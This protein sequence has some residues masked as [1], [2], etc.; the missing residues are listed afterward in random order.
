MQYTI[1]AIVREG[2]DGTLPTEIRKIIW[3]KA[4]AFERE[5][6]SWW[7]LGNFT[8]NPIDNKAT[9]FVVT[10]QNASVKTIYPIVALGLNH[11]GTVLYPLEHRVWA[12][13]DNNKWQ[14]VEVD[15]CTVREQQGFICESNTIKAQDICLDTEHNV[16][17]FEIH[18]KEIPGTVLI[19]WERMCVHKNS[20]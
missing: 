7:Y 8:H 19:Y 3:E 15:A 9:A 13:R 20:M 1:A 18:P 6:Q 4:T 10:I 12:Q 16:C 11:N 2:E 14:T 5:F 17:H